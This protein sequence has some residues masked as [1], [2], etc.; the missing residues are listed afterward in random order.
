MATDDEKEDEK[1]ERIAMSLENTM[2]MSGLAVISA[3]GRYIGISADELHGMFAAVEESLNELI[4]EAEKD[5]DEKPNLT[6]VK[7]P[8][9]KH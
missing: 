3:F 6:V 4:V 1:H 5:E 9:R 8:R 7:D 2:V